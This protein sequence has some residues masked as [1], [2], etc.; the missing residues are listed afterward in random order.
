[1]PALFPIIAKTLSGLEEALAAELQEMGIET[2]LLHR[3]VRFTGTNE[4]LYRANYCSRLA[5]RFLK[6]ITTFDVRQQEDLYTRIKEIPWEE[7]ITESQSLAIDAVISGPVFSNS[8]FVAQKTKDAIA[9]RFRTIYGKRPSVDLEHP[10]LRIHVHLQQEQCTVF[11]DSSGQSLHKRGYRQRTWEAP[12]SEVLAAGMIRLSGWDGRTPLYDPMCGSG[13][14]PMEA[15]ML[16]S[17]TPAGYFRKEFA[18]MKWR[19]FDRELWEKI[20]SEADASIQTVS[21]P[22]RG[23][24]KSRQAIHAAKINIRKTHLAGAVQLMVANFHATKPPF[25]Q[26]YLLMNPPYDE[27]IQL[28]DVIAFYRS[29][30]DA[31]KH[32]YSGWQAWI[33]S[34]DLKALK[35]VGLK[36]SLKIPLFNGPLECRFVKFDLYEGTKKRKT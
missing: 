7:F 19:D 12:L 27:R 21:I 3:A 28:D 8:L 15:A 1:M 9:D 4:T 2:E 31:L 33:I 30:G 14:L 35:Y 25:E 34:S 29:L 23:T 26:G 24:D 22:I 18:L 13:T 6:Q 36:P 5:L 32:L 20:K 11:L 16:A 10:D 17:Q